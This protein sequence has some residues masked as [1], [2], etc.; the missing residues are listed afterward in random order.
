MQCR[1]YRR[2]GI[3]PRPEN[4][5]AQPQASLQPTKYGT[6]YTT[7]REQVTG[8]TEH[9]IKQTSQNSTP[10]QRQQP[11][12]RLRHPPCIRVIVWGIIPC[13]PISPHFFGV[14]VKPWIK[15]ISHTPL[16][17]PGTRTGKAICTL[18]PRG[19]VILTPL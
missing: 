9:S 2:W 16:K 6:P 15:P 4:V 18:L 19:P 1:H 10:P 7:N 3:T 12:T 5:F 17:P 11:A 14:P 13:L 8:R